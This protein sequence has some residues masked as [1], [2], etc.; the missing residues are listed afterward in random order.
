MFHFENSGL[1]LEQSHGPCLKP[2]H[3]RLATITNVSF[4]NSTLLNT[5]VPKT[6]FFPRSF[7]TSG[8]NSTLIREKD[9]IKVLIH[10]DW[11]KIIS[12]LF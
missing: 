2:F 8:N 12:L 10:L 9:R 1:V 6:G 5:S 3:S 11:T 7:K 4:G